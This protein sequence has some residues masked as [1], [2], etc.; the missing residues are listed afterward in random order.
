MLDSFTTIYSP[1]I[2]VLSIILSG[3]SGIRLDWSRRLRI[4]LGAAKGIQY[5]HDLANPPIIHR[6]IKSNNVLLDE[7]LNAKVSDFGL[8]KPMGDPERGHVTT[9]VKGT[10]V[11]KV[12]S[13]K[14]TLNN[15]LWLLHTLVQ[16]SFVLQFNKRSKVL[17]HLMSFYL[18]AKKWERKNCIMFV[19]LHI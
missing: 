2:I 9:Q 19:V 16:N 3:K 1:V 10:M 8:S 14:P 11:S 4:A 15:K 17:E 7:H 18:F 5:L 12:S 13:Q 6:D